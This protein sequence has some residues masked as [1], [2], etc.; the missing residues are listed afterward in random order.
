MTWF[1]VAVGPFQP[2]RVVTNCT[3]TG[4]LPWG[5]GVGENTAL[6]GDGASFSGNFQ[7]NFDSG[8]L[9]DDDLV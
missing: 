7:G 3:P 6:L 8:M 1:W 9:S 5:V 4:R 2:S